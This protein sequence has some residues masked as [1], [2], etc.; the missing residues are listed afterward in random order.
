MLETI[1][2]TDVVLRVIGAFYAF[3]GYVATRSAMMS[4]FLDQA[5]AAI[6]AQKPKPLETAQNALLLATSA[7]VLIGG[8][9]LLAGIE[10]AAWAFAISTLGQAAYIYY[11]APRF[12]DAVD[13]VAAGGRRQ[14]YG[15]F[16][17]DLLN[18]SEQ[19]TADLNAWALSYDASFDPTIRWTLWRGRYRGTRRRGTAAGGAPQARAAR[20]EDLRARQ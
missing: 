13:P 20:P 12:F 1:E 5:I 19:L 3:A 17:P 2:L 6:A 11:L 8:V 4:R 16:P 15:C 7:L 14:T 9:L 10:L 18:L